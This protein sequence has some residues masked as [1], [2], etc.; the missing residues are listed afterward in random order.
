[1]RVLPTPPG[2]VSVTSRV[3]RIVSLTPSSSLMRPIKDVS[4]KGTLCSAALD[5]AAARDELV[6]IALPI[7]T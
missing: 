6:T 4:G 2:P 1:M 5:R 7:I 3:L